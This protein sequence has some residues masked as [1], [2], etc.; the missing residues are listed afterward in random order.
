MVG[1]I[2][3]P[4]MLAAPGGGC[5]RAGWPPGWRAW[6]R[7]PRSPSCLSPACRP[8]AGRCPPFI[9]IRHLLLAVP[10]LLLLLGHNL[11]PSPRLAL[12]GLALT[13]GLGTWLAIADDAYARVYP[14]YAAQ[15]AASL[16]AGVTHWTMGHWGWQ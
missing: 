10:A 14:V 9:A 11:R 2:S 6:G 13:A 12:A 8:A 5:T 15:I 16:P 3:W 4:A 1:C 7:W